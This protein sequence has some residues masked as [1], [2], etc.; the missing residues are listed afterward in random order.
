MCSKFHVF[1]INLPVPVLLLLG[2][3]S[4]RFG[5]L[6]L[7]FLLLFLEIAWASEAAAIL[8]RPASPTPPVYISAH[9]HFLRQ[10][11][12]ASARLHAGCVGGFRNPVR[13]LQEVQGSFLFF[14]LWLLLLLVVP[15]DGRVTFGFNKVTISLVRRCLACKTVLP[16]HVSLFSCSSSFACLFRLQNPP[17]RTLSLRVRFQPYSD[18]IAKDSLLVITPDS[19]WPFLLLLHR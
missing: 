3:L 15:L 4:N 16:E 2:H 14:S 19:P 5:S 8:D 18:A 17:Y 7:V 11:N 9:L 10:C 13:P 12:P 6:S 1:F